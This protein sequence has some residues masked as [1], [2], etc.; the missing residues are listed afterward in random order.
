MFDAFIMSSRALK[1]LQK[2]GLEAELAGIAR[3]AAEQDSVSEQESDGGAAQTKTAFNAFAAFGDESENSS[4]E[5]DTDEEDEVEPTKEA[6]MVSST[7]AGAKPA[8]KSATRGLTV[9]DMD[10]DELDRLLSGLKVKPVANELDSDSDN[11][12]AYESADDEELAPLEPCAILEAGAKLLTPKTYVRSA[13]LLVLHPRDL[14]PDREYEALFG[15]LSS[16]AVDAADSTS[17]SFVSPEMLKDIKRL[18]KRVRGWSGRDHRSLPGTSRKLV[19]TKIRDDWIPIQKKPLAVEEMDR[20]ALAALFQA[21][22]PNDWRDV[23]EEDVQRDVR[24][25]LHYFQASPGPTYSTAATTEFFVST[26]VQPDHE[27]LIRLLQ[28]APYSLETILQVAAILQRQGDNSNTN[29]LIERA[30]FV[31]EWA[32]PAGLELGS[33]MARLPYEFFL[34]RQL[35]LV[36]IR[37]ISVLTQKGTFYTAFN[38]C[39]LLLSFD[40]NND[41]MGV[42]YFVDYY[43]FMAG[44]YKWIVDFVASPLCQTYVEWLTPGML[45][46]VA[47]AHFQLGDRA[48]AKTALANAYAAHPHTGHEL[49]AKLGDEAHPW[50]LAEPSSAVQM[51][52]AL[53]AVRAP[54][55]C[56]DMPLKQFVLA[57]LAAVVERVGKPAVNTYLNTVE[58]PTNLIRHVFLSNES[59]AMARIPPSFWAEHE[60]Y[61]FDVLPPSLGTTVYNYIDDDKMTAEMLRQSL[62]AEEI[63]D[64]DAL[65]AQNVREA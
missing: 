5:D 53:Y 37:Y 19:L 54:Q 12:S 45:Y 36:C 17:S 29:G 31:L 15:K 35:Y 51:A 63:R 1:R 42:R 48:S 30:L 22:S 34:N 41:P 60:V 8:L 13:H 11:M 16:A 65:L 3:V 21:R 40:P 9:D 50:L 20:T 38:Y 26:C 6:A 44:E 32:L 43:A 47:M 56:E 49:L 55:L 4:Q 24:A 62:Q 7:C 14:N 28:R 18:A 27:S 46:T 2:G 10:E 59:A 25:G 64:L 61:E 58:V 52:S 33:A 57:E 39:R 23:V